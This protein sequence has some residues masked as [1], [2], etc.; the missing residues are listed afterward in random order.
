MARRERLTSIQQKRIPYTHKW[1][2][3]IMIIDTE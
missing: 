3:S 2:T 1:F